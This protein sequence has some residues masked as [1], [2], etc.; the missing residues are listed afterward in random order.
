MAWPTDTLTTTHLDAATDDPSQA[1]VELKAAVDLLKAVI[2]GRATASGVC[3]LDASTLIPAARLSA[4]IL[5]TALGYTP[6]HAGNDGAGSGLDADL[7]DGLQATAF[8]RADGSVALTG[9]LNANSQDVDNA[10]TVTF[11]PE[12]DNG[13]SGTAK[14]VDWNN[15]QKQK[16]TLTGD[17][18][19]TFTAPLGPC[20]LVLKLI[21]DA[22]GSRAPTWPATVK[23]P[24][25]GEPPW[26][27]TA[28]K[29]DILALYFDGTDYYGQAAV[30][31]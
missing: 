21:Q 25:G 8:L 26:S 23:W 16:V 19:F 6:W 18:T 1:R 3:D 12:Y 2:A 17:C 15:A 13:N 30:G 9:D 29:I 10:K 24:V 22:T 14:T 28:G 20:N 11:I 7:L 31:Y 5:T 27:T 4:S